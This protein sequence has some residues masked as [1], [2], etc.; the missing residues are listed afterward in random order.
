[1][2]SMSAWLWMTVSTFLGDFTLSFAPGGAVRLRERIA[3][4]SVT[5][6]RGNH[7]DAASGKIPTCRKFGKT[8]VIIW[9]LPPALGA[10]VWL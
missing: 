5:L 8:C 9:R 1:M 7:D 6:I 3:C 2:P 10:I 4:Q